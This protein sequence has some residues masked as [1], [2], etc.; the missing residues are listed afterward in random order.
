M[1]CKLLL[2]RRVMKSF[3]GLLT[4]I[5]A[6][7]ELQPESSMLAGG[8]FS[9]AQVFQVVAA[10]GRVFAFRRIPR[11]S[12]LPEERLRALHRLLAAAHR[13]GF[14]EIPVPHVPYARLNG[15][16]TPALSRGTEN[17]ASLDPW[18]RIGTDLWQV[19][20]WMPGA[21]IRGGEVSQERLRS[22]LERL[23]QLH[24]ALA[25]HGAAGNPSA[26]FRNSLEPSPAILRRRDIV[27]ALLNGQLP[28]LRKRSAVDP[29]SGFRNAAA[30]VFRVLDDRL[31]WLLHELTRLADQSFPIQPALRD[32]WRAHVLFTGDRITGLIDLSAAASDHVAIDAA[33]LF[34]SWFGTDTGRI[35]DAMR[36]FETRYNIDRAEWQLLRALDAS[37]VLLSPVT[38]IRRRTVSMER[39]AC[40]AEMLTRFE[41]VAAIAQAFEPLPARQ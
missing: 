21:S 28:I 34:R 27:D 32:V 23:H 36:E 39:D 16:S 33:R 5:A 18:I 19:E 17:Q 41:E 14:I 22:A 8:G 20:P 30:K 1:L 26:W 37:S 6:R 31:P 2:W 35:I 40:P 38:W 7:F 24:A 29:D 10:G 13:S 9:G 15:D 3:D 11:Q 12:T 25:E 4:E